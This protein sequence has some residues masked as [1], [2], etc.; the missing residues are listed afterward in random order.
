MKKIKGIILVGITF[1]LLVLA[2]GTASAGVILPPG[3]PLLPPIVSPPVVET[4]PPAYYAYPYGYYAYPYGYY[5]YPYRFYGPRVW[6]PGYWGHG[7][8]YYGHRGHRWYRR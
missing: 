6:G 2:A 4:P 5:S 8:R 3:W 1:L 7:G